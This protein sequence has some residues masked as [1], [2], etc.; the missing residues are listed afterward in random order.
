MTVKA[1][2]AGDVPGRWGGEEFPVALAATSAAER[3]R[4]EIAAAPVSL[5]DGPLHVTASIGV[6]S[7]AE[8]GWED[9]SG[10]PTPAST[11]P[12]RAAATGS[13]P[14]PPCPRGPAV[15]S[16]TPGRENAAR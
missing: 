5:A 10:G 15:E 8:D 13:W 1:A 12:R 3:V 11:R 9:R 2:R 14:G 7:G 6:A 4:R 16:R